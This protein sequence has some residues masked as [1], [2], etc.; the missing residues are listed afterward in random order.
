MVLLMQGGGRGGK[1][2]HRGRRGED[3]R[4]EYLGL[5][6]NDCNVFEEVC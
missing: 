1:W 5:W 2:G 3:E 4:V 6:Q